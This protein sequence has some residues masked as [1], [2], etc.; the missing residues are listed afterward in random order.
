[1]SGTILAAIIG[2]IGAIA[3]ALLKRPWPRRP[4]IRVRM[5]KEHRDPNLDLALDL[6]TFRRRHQIPANERDDAEDIRRWVREV[7]EETRIGRCNLKDYFLVAKL[8]DKVLGFMYAHFYP[9]RGLAFISYIVNNPALA[10][11]RNREVTRKLVARLKREL[12]KKAKGCQ[13]I[14]F[15]LQIDEETRSKNSRAEDFR[16]LA[17]KEDVVLKEIRINYL[18]PKLSLWD[19]TCEEER[20]H[21]MYARIQQPYLVGSIPKDEIEKILEFIYSDIYGDQFEDDSKKNAEYRKYL[22]DLY[23]STVARLPETVHLL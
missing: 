12:T 22:E 13:G 23:T 8:K 5:I 20:L 3:A 2:G 15:E 11:G 17:R 10:E 1:M 21:L 19:T 9:R 6:L 16:Q 4:H 18:Q 7:E 14:L